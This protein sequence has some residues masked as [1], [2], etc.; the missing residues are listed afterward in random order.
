MSRESRTDNDQQRGR[1]P[2][3]PRLIS[4][5]GE[6]G[7]MIDEVVREAGLERTARILLDE[8]LDRSA[9]PI[10]EHD[11]RVGFFVTQGAQRCEMVLDVRG[12]ERPELSRTPPETEPVGI[13]VEYPVTELMRDVFGPERR[14]ASGRCRTE[15]LP[16][17]QPGDRT[18]TSSLPR[19]EIRSIVRAGS[20]VLEGCSNGAADL[21]R[22]ALEH[23]SNKW[24][25]IHWFTPHYERH[26]APLRDRQVRVLEIGI[27]GY[28]DSKLGG[29]SLR[30]WKRYFHR[31]LVYGLDVF[32]KS[33]VDQQ[34]ITTLRGSQDDPQLLAT[35]A[36]EFG[37]FDVIID[38]GSHLN[39]HIR[40]SFHTLLPHLADGGLYVIEDLWT[41]YC[42]GYRGHATAQAQPDTALGLVKSLVD[43]VH[44]EEHPPANGQPRP[45]EASIVGIHLYH[46]IVFLEKG[47]NAEGGIPA[48][49]ER[50]PFWEK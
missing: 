6:P 47:I 23:V 10:N 18:S 15:L 36:R 21:G 35:I 14:T 49:V 33:E 34:R 30:M 28:Q 1:G 3:L 19:E 41:S 25:G 39:D 40:T 27:G 12:G 50:E 24:G 4:V 31:G 46:N 16:A 22:L 43:D 26:F 38:D 42:P 11:A 29:G 32:D 20:A 8:V 45:T 9:T 5:A 7:P 37:P 48:W 17:P 2:L 13:L 44:H